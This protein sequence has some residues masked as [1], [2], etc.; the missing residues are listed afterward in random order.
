MSTRSTDFLDAVA[1][2]PPGATLSCQQVGWDEY[3]EI[4]SDLG[5]TPN[6]RV[7]YDEGR[8]EIVAPL[9][10]HERYKSLIHDLVVILGEELGIDV[11]P[12]G[13]ATLKRRMG[14]KGA[15]PDDCYY[16]NSSPLF[17]GKITLDLE[18]DPPP[19]IVLEVDTTNESL[20]KFGI[21][22]AL[23]VP[24]IWRYD[25]QAAH[26]Y[27]LSGTEYH[28]TPA[29]VHLPILAAAKLTEFLEIGKAERQ[30]AARRR[31]RKWVR[32]QIGT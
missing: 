32:E 15:E 19:D 6:V 26:F 8:L 24:E 20:S 23:G 18:Q 27:Q 5:N 2:L 7:S 16:F 28:D 4:L 12:L 10:I 22:A 31:F 1:H 17:Q 21:Y 9:A 11:E 29:S 25:G 30:T 13:S 3:M 14:A